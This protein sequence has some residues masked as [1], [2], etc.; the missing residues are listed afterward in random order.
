M[1]QEPKRQT[2]KQLE[3]HLAATP[4][5]QARSEIQRKIAFA[6]AIIKMRARAEGSSG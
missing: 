1:E 3:A 6:E 5:G 4:A 2:L